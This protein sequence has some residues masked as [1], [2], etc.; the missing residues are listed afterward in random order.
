[1]GDASL[2]WAAYATAIASLGGLSGLALNANQRFS[3]APQNTFSI[4]VVP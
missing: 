3:I 4:P 2:I 1:M